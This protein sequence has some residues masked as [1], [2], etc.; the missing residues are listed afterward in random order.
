VII[1]DLS[2]EQSNVVTDP[3]L[4]GWYQTATSAEQSDMCQF[5]FGPD[6]AP[7]P[8]LTSEQQPANAQRISN[9]TINNHEYYLQLGFDSVGVTAGRGLTCWSGVALAAR[10]TAPNPVN[11]GDVVGFDATESNITLNAH[12]Q[13][14]PP[15]EPYVAPLYTWN[16]G[17]GTTVTGSNTASQFH[18]YAQ[19]GTYTVALTVTDSSGNSNT[20]SQPITVVGGSAGSGSGSGSGSVGG[21][22]TS[23]ATPGTPGAGTASPGLTVPNPVVTAAAVSR[24]L[25]SVLRKGLVVRYSVNEQVAGHFEVL[26]SKTIARRLGISGERALG[27]AAGS[28]PQVIIARAVLVTTRAGR[29]NVVIQ[30]S[31]R[32]ATR[33]KRLHKVTLTLRLIV[34]NAASG[35]PA[36]TT[37]LSTVT[38]AG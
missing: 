37:V 13:G 6:P 34:R 21:T 36:S 26:L 23:V 22:S 2:V 12:T 3:L 31:K 4:N 17:D 10:F 33:L 18:S 25:R 19:G 24:S 14:L 16:F 29:S 27:L 9:E 30:L 7:L 28:P 11:A 32:T 8:P 5:A 15:D 35:T 1:N 20:V 38:L